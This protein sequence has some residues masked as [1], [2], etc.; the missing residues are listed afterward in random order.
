M[1]M[2]SVL[3]GKFKTPSNLDSE[4]NKWPKWHSRPVWHFSSGPK[5]RY[6][7]SSNA[8]AKVKMVRSSSQIEMCLMALL[9]CGMCAVSVDHQWFLISYQETVS[10]ENNS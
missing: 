8:C 2:T 10:A 7:R 3:W 4:P 5:C 1:A 6:E 9:H